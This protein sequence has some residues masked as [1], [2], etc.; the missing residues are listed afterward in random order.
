MTLAKSH[1]DVL[2]IRADS[3]AAQIRSAYRKLVMEHH[4]DRSS[5]AG[6]KVTFHAASE[7]YEVLGDPD[8]RREYDNR[9]RVEAQQKLQK[10]QPK[11]SPRPAAENRPTPS[12]R[13][14]AIK[15]EIT[16]LSNLF[17]RGKYGDAEL[18]AKDVLRRDPRQAVP[19]AVLG[20]LARLKGDRNQALKMY[21]YAAQFEP[22]NPVFQRRYEELLGAAQVLP[23]K[24]GE[25]AP[26]MFAHFFGLGL[27]LIACIYVVLARESPLMPSFKLIST[28]TL[29]T[30]GMLFFTGVVMG[31]CLALDGLLDS[32][33]SMSTNA[34]GRMSP[35]LALAS[36]AIVNFWAAVGM[37]ALLGWRRQAF[38]Y[39]T[40][41]VLAIVAAGTCLLALA[42]EAS[43]EVSGFQVVLWGGN[44]VYMGTL[45]GWMVTD[46]LRANG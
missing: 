10:P 3:T 36:I 43:G 20:D 27:I 14:V 21:A 22:R 7:A 33:S 38:N 15:D 16:K 40:S 13:M 4:P 1:Y 41:R 46:A 23:N 32:F 39:S 44:L 24:Q 25:Q 12:A 11:P 19:Y 28:W 29:G 30:V 6:S 26:Q 8:R 17:S 5:S 18:L 45:C 9:L 2:G 35:T 37:Y 34:L 42:A 31:S